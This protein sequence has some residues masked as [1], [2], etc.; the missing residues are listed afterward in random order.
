MHIWKSKVA[1]VV[2]LAVYMLAFTVVYSR[3]QHKICCKCLM[4]GFQIFI[5][6]YIQDVSNR[7]RPAAGIDGV[8]EQCSKDESSTCTSDYLPPAPAVKASRLA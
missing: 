7:W 1:A 3:Q 6:E 8:D 5:Y 2:V 4:Q